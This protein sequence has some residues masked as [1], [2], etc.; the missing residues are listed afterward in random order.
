MS[1]LRGLVGIVLISVSAWAKLREG[2]PH[3]PGQK[4]PRYI[5]VRG[6]AAAGAR[7][8]A[9]QAEGAHA[10]RLIRHRLTLNGFHKL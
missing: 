6:H 2:Q 1:V 5:T 4:H 8:P 10:N 3:D 7:R 9:S